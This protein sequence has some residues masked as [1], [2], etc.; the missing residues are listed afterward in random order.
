[1]AEKKNKPNDFVGKGIYIF[2]NNL[3][4]DLMLPK[5]SL[6]NKRFV[7]PH[8]L[9]K[10]DSSFLKMVRTNELKL[11]EII[12]T[13]EPKIMSENKLIL[14]QP[15]MVKASGKVEHIQASKPNVQLNDSVDNAQ[16]KNPDVLLN[17]DP[18]GS[19]QIIID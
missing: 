6:D 10:G 14:D 13:G 8:K 9:F 15:D 16:E 18:A 11:I 3:N 17:E 12:D 4:S 5:L 7:G 2:E 1:M 19:I